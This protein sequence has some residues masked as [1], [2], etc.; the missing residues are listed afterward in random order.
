MYFRARGV[1]KGKAK[2]SGA[3]QELNMLD[4]FFVPSKSGPLITD[5][6]L[7]ESYS[8][9][10]SS[11]EKIEAA[12]AVTR[13]ILT[14]PTDFEDMVLWWQLIDYLSVLET[15]EKGSFSLAPSY[16]LLAM[17]KMHGTQPEFERCVLCGTEIIGGSQC[18]FS[19]RNGGV[20]GEECKKRE[21]DLISLIGPERATLV[22]WKSLALRDVLEQE[23][24]AETER[25]VM[26]IVE[27][28]CAWHL[29]EHMSVR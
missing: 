24:L 3:L 22:T 4:V 2:H 11:P 10:K 20:V 9:I 19:V 23:F 17:L 25:D 26:N 27:K 16:F 15:T 21:D 28:Y 8:N 12:R 13:V 5:T 29:G 14:F 7:Q 1:R 18:F 6:T